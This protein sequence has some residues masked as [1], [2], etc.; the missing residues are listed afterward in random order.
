M[1]EFMPH[2]VPGDDPTL[3]AAMPI[4]R[5]SHNLS[6]MLEELVDGVKSSKK[7][8]A[9][10]GLGETPE[11]HVQDRSS[12]DS[13][14]MTPVIP[15]RLERDQ[16]ATH[17]HLDE[18]L[19]RIRFVLET[20][21][22]TE[23]QALLSGS[24]AFAFQYKNRKCLGGAI[25]IAA[26]HREGDGV[27]RSLLSLR[28]DINAECMYTASGRE[29]HAQAIHLAAQSSYQSVEAL[30]EAGAK[31]DARSRV[32][33][34]EHFC[35]IHEAAFF[36][37]TP[38]LS[39]LLEC[40]AEVNAANLDSLTALHVSAKMGNIDSAELLIRYNADIGLHDKDG[41][42]AL[43]LAVE[44]GVF[45]QRKLHLLGKFRIQDIMVVAQHS[46]SA[47][48]EFMKSL[49]SDYH[50]TCSD[51]QMAYKM[52]VPN[53][54]QADEEV[55]VSHW[56][57][58]MQAA[59]DAANYLL[60]NLT[61]EPDED[62]VFYHPLPKQAILHELRCDYNTDS[63]WKCD[64]EKTVE[65]NG[66]RWPE[67]HERLAPGA[68]KQRRHRGG[69]LAVQAMPTS[70]PSPSKDTVDP[71]A[72]KAVHMR[73]LRLRG[74]LCNE[75]LA[76]LADTTD[77]DSFRHH[78]IQAIL[79]FVWDAFV[80][81][82]FVAM[83]VLRILELMVLCFYTWQRIASDT[84]REVPPFQR[85]F[86]WSILCVMSLRDT[87]R[88]LF[89]IYGWAVS[90]QNA[91]GYFYKPG[92]YIDLGTILTFDYILLT[93]LA[94]G[95]YRLD[96]SV[97][98]GVGIFAL[99][100]LTRWL[101]MMFELRAFE[102]GGIGIRGLIPILHS[103]RKISAMFIICSFMTCGF[104]HSF[105]V[106]DQSETGS[107]W[108]T[109]VSTLNLLFMVGDDGINYTL[110]LGGRANE[111]DYMTAFFLMTAV[112]MFCISLLN[113]FIAVHG[114]AYSEAHAQA[115]SL[116]LQER[117]SICLH[118]MMQPHVSASEHLKCCCRDARNWRVR[119]GWT[120]LAVVSF[121][122]W[123]A[124][125]QVNDCHPTIPMV[126][127]GIAS[128]TVSALLLQRPWLDEEERSK[129]FLWWCRPTR[130]A[131][132]THDDQLHALHEISERM[133]RLERALES[134]TASQA[135]LESPF[136][137]P[138]AK[139]AVRFRNSSLVH[140]RTGTFA[141]PPTDAK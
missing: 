28:A 139:T 13:L 89:Q 134:F 131:P 6:L 56:L 70:K 115:T 50:G 23:C 48:L 43:E 85:R 66:K 26:L 33:G 79:Q 105:L 8:G 69:Q 120:M 98:S 82:W 59:P 119:A 5:C 37:N 124:L 65:G 9:W 64:T 138:P 77:L 52:H 18:Q 31:V 10:V 87:T 109:I 106:L 84:G 61:I 14:G 122:L 32:G 38:V 130:I 73:Q 116:F 72:L 51:S 110:A 30:L 11:D 27:L 100:V 16:D 140:R 129:S 7:D 93:S 19:L 1:A 74:V 113:L 118:G 97:G 76:V 3:A 21:N 91:K 126:F 25:H 41:K 102:L 42:T 88:E 112:V 125:I 81:R 20:G 103:I 22:V 55:Q 99:T 75:V 54:L 71:A 57:E 17:G 60:E 86:S 123:I 63:T 137:S 83:F 114:Q 111:G 46:P 12:F 132:G 94:D 36:R 4:A 40:R 53:E 133:F 39:Y 24:H 104:I 141:G 44:S 128:E 95:S 68:F 135:P 107:S 2:V 117:A 136:A 121:G 47:T 108:E 78:A 96:S 92:N 67:W 45:P 15:F 29:A 58:L 90:L 127:L 62:S 49:L 34:K 35:P 80:S 101:R